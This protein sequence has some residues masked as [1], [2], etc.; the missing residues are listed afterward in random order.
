[1]GREVKLLLGSSGRQL[2]TRIVAYLDRNLNKQLTL[3]DEDTYARANMEVRRFSN[4]NIFVRLIDS[5]R[6]A[7]VFI[8]QSSGTPVNDRLVELLITIDACRRSSAGCINVILPYFPYS[9][10]DKVDQPRVAITARLVADLIQTAGADRVITMDLHADQIQG[11]FSIA[12]D[13]LKATTPLASYVEEHF[14]Q[15]SDPLKRRQQWVVIAPDA[16]AAKR[17]QDFARRLDLDLAVLLKQRPGN[18]DISEVLHVMG[19]VRGRNC[20]IF[21]DE[22]DTG[23][24]LVNCINT[25]VKEHGVQEAYAVVTHGVF[26]GQGMRT[27]NEAVNLKGVVVTDTLDVA[28]IGT[29]HTMRYRQGERIIEEEVLN[30]KV[31]VCSVADLFAATIRAVHL[32]ESVSKVYEEWN[33]GHQKAYT[34]DA[35]VD[36]G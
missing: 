23:G 33:I 2:G 13:H 18:D 16:G 20:L 15:E 30:Q 3:L 9:R 22:I 34:L 29:M 12:V 36:E 4:D 32:G 5:V 19:D 21:D 7:D 26:S 24:T 25:L 35:G 11:F 27:V 31:H 1:M 14:I 8:L 10:S 6:E 17:A 28:P